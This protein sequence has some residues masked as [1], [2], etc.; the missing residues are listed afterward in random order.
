M[1]RAG[2]WYG[3]QVGDALKVAIVSDEKLAAPQCLIITHAESVE[4]DTEYRTAIAR[5]RA[6]GHHRGDMGM[7]MLDL[8][9]RQ[10]A[11]RG[12]GAAVARGSVVGV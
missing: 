6:I 3:R 4:R 8:E 10:M 11:S 5:V 12:Q 2:E 7:V 9:Q 1:S